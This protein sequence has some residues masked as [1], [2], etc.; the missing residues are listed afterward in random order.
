MSSQHS[1]QQQANTPGDEQAG[2]PILRDRDR[3]RAELQEQHCVLDDLGVRL[4]VR[5]LSLDFSPLD[6]HIIDQP[7][8]GCFGLGIKHT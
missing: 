1:P 3:R 8:W 4:E 7:P 5:V 2:V 6:N